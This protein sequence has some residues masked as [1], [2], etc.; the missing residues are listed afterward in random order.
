MRH[1]NI[2][3]VRMI[4]GSC[5][6]WKQIT[7]LEWVLSKR[8]KDNFEP[9]TIEKQEKINLR[10]SWKNLKI[11]HFDW[12]G[13]ICPDIQEWGLGCL[14]NIVGCLCSCSR[15]QYTE[16]NHNTLYN[17]MK[18]INFYHFDDWFGSYFLCSTGVSQGV[19]GLWGMMG[20]RCYTTDL[21][22]RQ[23]TNTHLV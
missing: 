17:N 8:Q 13:F 22:T 19:H 3:Q 18:S 9:F 21:K 4:L 14:W 12:L 10:H 16:K 23:I 2:R 5:S 7:F 20:R 11:Y 6:R 1:V 15:L